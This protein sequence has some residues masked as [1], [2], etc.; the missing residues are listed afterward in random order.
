[1][2]V[3]CS[4]VHAETMAAT[5]EVSRAPIIFSHSSSRAVC[6]HPR[7]VPDGVLRLLVKN[8]GVVMVT[9][10]SGF[11]AGEFWVR[12]GKVGATVLE[13]ADHIDHIRTVSGIDHIG[14]GGDYDGCKSL[15]RGLEDVSGY[16][17]LT[18]E[19]LS[20]GYSNDDIRKILSGNLFR[21]MREAERIRDAM[22]G[23]N[24]LPSEA[25]PESF[26]EGL[27]EEAL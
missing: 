17:T 1:M 3:D 9:F 2:L 10:V 24:V 12:G 20:R 14:I 16:P 7:D 4:H 19:L 25:T 13:V 6:N 5:L 15:A 21:V 11:V 26:G 23:E 27:K 8:G 18:A 22:E